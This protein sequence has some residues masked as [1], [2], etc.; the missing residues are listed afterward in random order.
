[1][2]HSETCGV[3][4]KLHVL[5]LALV[6]L[7]RPADSRDPPRPWSPTSPPLGQTSSPPAALQ[8]A[9]LSAKRAALMADGGNAG[10]ASGSSRWD[11]VP[12]RRSATT[13]VERRVY[14]ADELKR[15]G[16]LLCLLNINQIFNCC[17]MGRS[18]WD[19]IIHIRLNRGFSGPNHK[20]NNWKN[21]W[22]SKAS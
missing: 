22:V 9:R 6:C 20:V 18:W 21:N 19:P 13:L 8:M 16:C 15:G 7:L 5:R 3:L 1:M 17:N 11:V 2:R 4:W 12:P 14:V 10:A